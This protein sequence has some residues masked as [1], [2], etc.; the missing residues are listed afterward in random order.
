MTHQPTSPDLTASTRKAHIRNHIW[1]LL[2]DQRV[3]VFP[4]PIKGRIPNFRGAEQAATHLL[5]LPE[6]A[7]ARVLKINPDAPQ[8]PLRYRALR[9]GKTV[10]VPTP[11]LRAGF[12]LLD[13]V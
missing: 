11:R 8:R 5:A 6:V 12:F 2:E 9:A 13:P 4:R 1:A 3:A 7:A 10:L